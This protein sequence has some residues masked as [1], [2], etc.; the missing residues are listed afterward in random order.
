MAAEAGFC[1]L[2]RQR[3]TTFG[4]AW[5]DSFLVAEAAPTTGSAMRSISAGAPEQ[6]LSPRLSESPSLPYPATVDQRSVIWVYAIA[7]VSLHLLLPLALVPWLFSWT[8]LLMI[9]LGN[10]VFGSLGINIGYH[11]LLTHRG[12]RCPKWLERSFIVLGVCCMQ[13]SPARWV[14]IHRLHHQHSDDQPDPHSPLVSWFW[15]HMGWL[16]VEN[17]FFSTI[18]AYERYARDILEDPFYMWLERGKKWIWIVLAQV[19]VFFAAGFAIGWGTS[20]VALDGV[21][22]G[23]SLLLWGVVVRTVFTWHITWAINSVTHLWGYRNYATNDNSKNTWLF[24]LI[25]NGEGWHNN[26]HAFP[27]S[28]AHGHRWWELDIT[29]LTIRLLAVLG[30]A[31]DVVT[32]KSGGQSKGPGRTERGFDKAEKQEPAFELAMSAEPSSGGF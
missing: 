20:G 27:R 15:G 5:M 9:P 29:Y 25:N 16:L 26:H 4:P 30:L 11:R 12:F 17:R 13:D 14:A 19:P 18:T 28:A 21:Q 7:F 3:R 8:G 6:H 22:F 32:H 31:T 23:L 10:Y 24:G 2:K 1:L